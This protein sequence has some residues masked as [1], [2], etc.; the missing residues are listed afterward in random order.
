[1]LVKRLLILAPLVLSV[2]LLQSYLWVPTYETQAVGNP[3]RL[4][5]YIEGSI[6]D[7]KI[8]NPIL[9]ADSSSSQI[10]ALTFDG[11]LDFDENLKLR[12]RLATDWTITEEAYLL[13]HPSKQFPDGR[14]V[15]GRA[16]ETRIRGALESGAL[17]D[18]SD[19]V[20]SVELRPAMTREER[21]SVRVKPADGPPSVIEV[22][23]TI[24]VP[25]RVAMT[26]RKVD[27]DL[28]T[29][30]EP[31]IGK[32]YADDFPY[33]RFIIIEGNQPKE[34][35]EQVRV[36]FLD[37]LPVEEHNPIILFQLRRGVLFHDGHEFD[38]GDVKFTYEAIMNPKNLSPRTSDFEP[39][40]RIEILDRFTVRVVYKRLFSPAINAWGMGMLPEHL[41]NPEALQRET[42]A[43]GLSEE[44]GRT[45]GMRDSR[46]N[47]HPIGTGPFQ[48]VEWQTDEFIHLVRNDAYWDGPPEYHD[49]YMRIIPDLLTQE[50]EFLAGAVDYYGAMPHQVARY[51]NDQT[52]QSFSTLARAYTYIGYNIRRPLFADP[53]VRRAL[54]MAINVN[55]FIEYI[56]YGEGER[57]TGPYPKNT[58][59][60][61][62]TVP[63]LQYD[64]QGA[65]HILRDLGWKRN[66][67]GWLEK[68][69][70]IFE[71]NLI[72]NSGNPLRKN[73]MTIAQ[74]EWKKIGIKCNTQYFEWAVFL[75]DFVNTGQF[76]ALVLGWSMGI[77]PD[78][79]QIW[80]SSQSGPQR[81]NFVGYKNPEADKLI[82]RI[83]REYDPDRQRE[84]AH[85]LHELI[86][87]DQP[88]TFLYAPLSTAVLDKKIVMVTRSEGDEEQ[89]QKIQPTKSGNLFF[90]FNK[91]RK[92]ELTPNF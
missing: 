86:A 9:N 19:L 41:L 63:P 45:F 25:E 43:R 92:L 39:V 88:Y 83:R 54:G 51:R 52:Y 14:A 64:P 56:L 80:H 3:D 48:F 22:P 55:E 81:L 20:Q 16:L 40:G 33:Q 27:Q 5:T 42:K 58:E 7:A 89:F 18:L 82:V 77:D 70:K 72:T 13:V 30:L 61:D 78:L 46:F 11:L 29:K 59:W 53:R 47:R 31:V 10:V 21:L 90:H 38:A 26:L 60:Y 8:L 62:H 15:S 1:M 44:A 32:H 12:P 4:R 75:Q 66:G 69:G 79:Y 23:V 6:G 67:D 91:W 74:N 57:T 68:D 35:Q 24:R 34:A 36:R 49:Y 65:L 50:V 28:F 87:E 85:R 17:D 71:F 84:Y 76:D 73:I 2:V 37:L